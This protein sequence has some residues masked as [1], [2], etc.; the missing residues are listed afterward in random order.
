[1]KSNW[2]EDEE[3]QEGEG[4]EEKDHYNPLTVLTL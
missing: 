3:A 1:V 4:K 2:K